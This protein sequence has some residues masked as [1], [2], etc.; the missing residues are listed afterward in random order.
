MSGFGLGQVEF[1]DSN[2]DDDIDTSYEGFDWTPNEGDLEEEP[3]APPPPEDN[4]QD[5]IVSTSP[6]TN[7]IERPSFESVGPW[8]G[9]TVPYQWDFAYHGS[10]VARANPN[11]E[12]LV[13][14]SSQRIA[15]DP[16]ETYW[17]TGWG[18]ME[19]YTSGAARLLIQERDAYDNILNTHII[20]E[21]SAPTSW[22]ATVI[23]IPPTSWYRCGEAS[24][25]YI[26]TMGSVAGTEVGSHT[27]N[28]SGVVLADSDGATRLPGQSGSYIDLGDNFDFTGNSAFTVAGWVKSEDLTGSMRLIGKESTSSPDSGWY[29]SVENGA[30]ARLVRYNNDD[31]FTQYELRNTPE[32]GFETGLWYHI[33]ATWDGTSG[34]VYVNGVSSAEDA[35]GDS[36][37]LILDSTTTCR[38][39]SGWDGDIDEVTIWQYALNGDEVKTIYDSRLAQWE[40]RA[41]RF[42]VRALTE[43]DVSWDPDTAQVSLVADTSGNPVFDFRLDG[44][45]FSQGEQTPTGVFQ[46]ETVSAHSDLTGIGADDHHSQAHSLTGSDHTLSG[47]TPGHVLTA[48]T[49]TTAAFA[50][51][52]SDSA[53]QHTQGVADTTWTVNHNL[54][55]YPAVTVLDSANTEIECDVEHT[56][57]NQVVLTLAYATSGIATCS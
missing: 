20:G 51:P 19:R 39:G 56:S 49:A 45:S 13:L 15:V 47:L 55:R 25:S 34:E 33:C 17:M 28:V 31:S 48:Q 14:T 50:A 9:W 2:E 12:L 44:L 32:G 42:R 21:W 16:T 38:I 53:Y 18:W 22:Y 54:G 11:G 8:S 10:N 29:V 57:T 7:L 1:I 40:N 46:D 24:G 35:T 5:D 27:R 4:V 26:D 6:G 36:G 3:S 23:N 41:T 37:V 43:D 52:P 30:Y